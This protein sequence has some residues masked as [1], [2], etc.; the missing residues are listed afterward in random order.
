MANRDALWVDDSG[1]TIPVVVDDEGNRVDL[2]KGDTVA[3]PAPEP[4]P[5]GGKGDHDSDGK[6]GGAKPPLRKKR[7]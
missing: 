2:A 3:E 7:A 6:V 5:F 1:K 4:E